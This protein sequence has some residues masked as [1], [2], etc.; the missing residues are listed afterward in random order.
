[1][2]TFNLPARA[3]VELLG[4]EL[5]ACVMHGLVEVTAPERMPTTEQESLV[6]WCNACRAAG[7]P[8][9]AVGIIEAAA[10]E[11]AT[12][13]AQE[14]FLWWRRTPDVL[15]AKYYGPN[16]ADPVRL[17]DKVLSWSG[18]ARDALLV[19]AAAGKLARGEWPG[20]ELARLKGGT[21]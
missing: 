8:V 3:A 7:T 20:A 9:D 1:M 15:L 5:A 21:K 17:R 14:A 2:S 13:G 12:T 4:D 10:E 11:G 16:G 6:R 18:S 19:E